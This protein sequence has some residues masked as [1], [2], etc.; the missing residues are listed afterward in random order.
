MTQR[1]LVAVDFSPASDHALTVAHALATRQN[2]A[3]GVV[4][5]MPNVAPLSVLFPQ[6][7]EKGALATVELERRAADALADRVRT[8]T[9]REGDAA[10]LFIEVGTDYAGI[11]EAAEKWNAD[12]V[13]VGSHGRTGMKRAL[14]GSVSEKVARTSHAPVLVTRPGESHRGPVIAATD[15]SDASFA[16]VE[17]GVA[18]A[19]ARKTELVV[20]HVVDTLPLV[21]GHIVSGPLGLA[22]IGL[23]AAAAQ[24]LVSTGRAALDSALA[25]RGVQA[26]VEA[27]EGGPAQTVVERAEALDAQLL[28]VSTHGRTG[29]K[30]ALLGSVA[31]SILRHAPCSTLVVRGQ[32]K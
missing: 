30:R 15:L 28:V 26:K 31:E 2:A 19:A 8:I 20:L 6:A 22:G 4:H 27:V 29:L 24:T 5:V 16:A 11:V 12:L 1:I 18:E 17:I 25:A 9:G 14:I 21:A 13:V 23:D 32:Q 10:M 3:L 7:V